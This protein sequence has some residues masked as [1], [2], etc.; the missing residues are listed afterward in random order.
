MGTGEGVNYPAKEESLLSAFH[1]VSRASEAKEVV[2]VSEPIFP[3]TLGI[4]SFDWGW[5]I[6]TYD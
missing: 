1:R 3:L 5:V 4:L 2:A 6:I